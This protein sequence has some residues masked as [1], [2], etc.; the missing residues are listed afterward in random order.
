MYKKDARKILTMGN[1]KLGNTIASWTLPANKEVCG[2]E[3]P[4]CYA[5]K[6]QYMYP[7]VS[8]SREQKYMF[9]K[10]KEFKK[11]IIEAAKVLQP[12]YIRVHDSGEFYSQEY[13]DNWAKIAKSFPEQIFYAYTKRMDDFNFKKLKKLDN[14]ILIN[15]LHNGRINYG[16]VEN[17]PQ[18]MFLC[19]D[20]KGS[21]ARIVQPK[22]PICGITCTYCMSKEAEKTGVYFVQH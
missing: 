12:K 20:H 22:D 13:V 2:R 10:E 21:E 7:A 18:D 3:C 14:F 1:H 17:R 16:T 19:P 9:S 5:I 8:P 15:S 11:T 4:G 6:A